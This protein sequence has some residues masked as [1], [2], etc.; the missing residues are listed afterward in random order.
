MS[1]RKKTLTNMTNKE[2]LLHRYKTQVMTEMGLDPTKDLSDLPVKEC[3]RL[4][5]LISKLIK[6]D[7]S[8][9]SK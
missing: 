6:K 2:L 8:F 5:G 7:K 9:Y 1:K 3:G 4:G